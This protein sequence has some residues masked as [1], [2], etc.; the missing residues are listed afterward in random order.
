M[1]RPV[2]LL[3]RPEAA[4]STFLERLEASG[5]VQADVVIS[6]LIGIEPVGDP[7]DLDAFESLVLTSQNAVVRLGD[8]IAGRR[9]FTVGEATA[10]AARV[11]GASATCLGADVASFLDRIEEVVTPAIH[12]H[13][14]H[15]TGGL[16]EAA[17]RKGLRVT[18]RAI[19][20][21]PVLDLTDRAREALS[22]ESQ[23]VAPLFSKRTAAALRKGTGSRLG[24]IR[25]AAISEA[26]A[27]EV[28]DAQEIR[29]AIAPDAASMVR[30]T[31]DMLSD[32]ALAGGRSALRL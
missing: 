4:S 25:I 21:Q 6:P 14:V 30:L 5:P 29:I 27:Q 2:L 22:G 12:L 8:A 20:D 23:L 17:H 32:A 24:R 31:L 13:G 26:V 9:V 15:V 28:P 7:G 16:V 11:A 3:T 18:G 19:Y 1:T 10:A